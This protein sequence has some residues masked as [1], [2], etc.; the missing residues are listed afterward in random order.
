M[1]HGKAQAVPTNERFPHIRML[2]PPKINNNQPNKRLKAN[3]E[4]KPHKNLLASGSDKIVV[5]TTSKKMKQSTP[6]MVNKMVT[7]R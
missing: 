5:F 6:N 7:T 2:L 1:K 4:I 3:L